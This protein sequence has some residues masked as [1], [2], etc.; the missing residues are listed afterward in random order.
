MSSNSDLLAEKFTKGH[1]YISGG[2]AMRM[3]TSFAPSSFSTL[4]FSRNCVPLTIESSQKRQRLPSNMSLFGIN[5]I[6]ATRLRTS[7]LGG[8]KER[9]HVGVY[10][11][12]P[13]W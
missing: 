13:L 7:W 5:F 6:L 2:Q 1:A 3:C 10:L 9:G 12:M 8:M 11:L 4:A